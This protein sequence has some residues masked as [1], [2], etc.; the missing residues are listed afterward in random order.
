MGACWDRADIDVLLNSAAP[1]QAF[2]AFEARLESALSADRPDLRG[3]IIAALEAA[4]KNGKPITN[5]WARAIFVASPAYIRACE[6][7]QGPRSTPSHEERLCD[8]VVDAWAAW[9]RPERGQLLSSI[10]VELCDISLVCA[11]FR[12][13]DGDWTEERAKRKAEETYFGAYT[14]ALRNALFGKVKELAVSGKLWSQASPASICWFWFACGQEQQVYVFIQRSMRDASSLAALL[15]MPIDRVDSTQ[16]GSEV[17]AVRRWSKLIDFN[18][19][20]NRAL[21]LVMSGAAKADKMRAR[22]F[23]DAYATGKSDLFK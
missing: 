7:L 17:I 13:V 5:E 6:Q 18:T 8:L 4:F 15:E 14:E 21:E 19:L 2:A 1:S 9:T 12:S 20:E 22:R 3:Q 11:L 16:C 23:L 10:M